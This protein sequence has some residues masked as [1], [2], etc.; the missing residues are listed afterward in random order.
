MSYTEDD[1]GTLQ[2]ACY[3]A[4]SDALRSAYKTLSE[5][6][7]EYFDENRSLH[8]SGAFDIPLNFRPLKDYERTLK[9]QQITLRLA[10][11]AVEIGEYDVLNKME[12]SIHT[13][14]HPA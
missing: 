10:L 11:K 7:S 3:A 5:S 6:I 14:G 1:G 8:G 2:K 4:Y 9:I 12:I 13:N